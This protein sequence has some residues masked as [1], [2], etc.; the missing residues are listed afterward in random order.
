MRCDV[1]TGQH[2]KDAGGRGVGLGRVD[3]EPLVRLVRRA[4]LVNDRLGMY[5][6]LEYVAA[7]FPSFFRWMHLREGAYA[8]GFEPS[9]HRVQGETAARED[10]SMTFLE[11]GEERLYTTTFRVGRTG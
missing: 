2:R 5:F 1:P 6:E 4:E 9:T 8:V 3:D 10:G 11:P 7:Q